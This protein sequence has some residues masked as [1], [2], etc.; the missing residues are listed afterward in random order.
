LE[1]VNYLHHKQICHRDLKPQ[2]IMFLN[3]EPNSIIKIIDYGYSF[4]FMIKKEDL[5]EVLGT[6]YYM[7]PELFS[8]KYNEKCD[9][10]SIGVM[11]YYSICLNYPFNGKNRE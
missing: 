5:N 8:G 9:L 7:A 1:C 6:P 3:D 4:N 10:W 11:M 2:N